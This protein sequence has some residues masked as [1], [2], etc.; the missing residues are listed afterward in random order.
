MRPRCRASSAR[1]T[2]HNTQG[3]HCT[4]AT[5]GKSLGATPG[6]GGLATMGFLAN[7]ALLLER[8]GA[9]VEPVLDAAESALDAVHPRSWLPG[10]LREL[11]PRRGEVY[12][13]GFGK[14]ARTMAEAAAEALGGRLAEGVVI[15]PRGQGGA[16]A[17]DRVRVLEGDHPVPGEATLQASEELLG[18]L[19]SLPRDAAVLVLVSGGG[20]ALF[21]KPAPGL[22]LEEVAEATRLLMLSGADIYE[23][24]ALRKHVSSVKGGQLLR[25][26][27]ARPVIAIYMSDVPGD[28]L[29]TVAS[30]PTVPDPTTYRD[31]YE[32]LRRHGLLDKAPPRIVE[33]LRRGMKGLEPETPKPGDPLFHG[34]LNK[35]G[36]RNRD[37]LTAA[38]NALEARGAETI[39]LTDTLRGEAREAAK[40]LAAILEYTA[41]ARRERP[42][43]LLAG[44][45]TTVTV[46]GDGRGGRNQELCIS[47]AAELKRLR[48][49]TEPYAALCM[50]TDGVDGNS[51]AAGG[52]ATHRLLEEAEKMDLDPLEA[53]RR[54]DSYTFLSRLGATLDTGGYTGVNVN[55]VF[56]AYL[57][58]TGEEQ[59]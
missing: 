38:A 1:L 16:V 33:R 50:G 49:L 18:F 12:L 29:D 34:V 56:I 6:P 22:T 3:I 54:N 57:P 58:G 59:G 51:P 26:I 41:E 4:G 30:G 8:W 5:V 21:E 20:S 42:L 36:T 52:L 44:G 53:L 46:T 32:A 23:L 39:V 25:Y 27:P 31:A 9:W 13:A 28:R 2:G 24:N 48:I 37:A 43:A 55:D 17:S 47:L 15:A 10:L 40:T 11:L 19:Q 45:E 14:A 7:R 35:L